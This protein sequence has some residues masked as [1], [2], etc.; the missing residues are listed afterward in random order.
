MGLEYISTQITILSGGSYKT[1]IPMKIIKEKWRKNRKDRRD[2]FPVCFIQKDGKVLLEIPEN[3]MNSDEYPEEMKTKAKE[4]YFKYI[5]RNT[6][7]K[8][9]DLST[10]YIEGKISHTEFES[11]LNK[12]S[13][14]LSGMVSSYKRI[15]SERELQFITL[16][17]LDKLLAITSIEEEIERE[18]AFILLMDDVKSIKEELRNYKHILG[19]LNEGFAEGR[20]SR[21]YYEVLR[22]RFLAKI[23]YLEQKINE[24]RRLICES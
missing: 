6:L 13:R 7:K 10:Q 11:R 14:E 3:M 18:E 22:E 9:E 23:E 8:Y 4:T 24:L 5:K 1:T 16:G 12:L 20:I 2:A 19:K 15:F 21:K 17:E